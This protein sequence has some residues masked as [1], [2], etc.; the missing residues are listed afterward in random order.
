MKKH[1][2]SFITLFFTCSAMT[3]A[4][5]CAITAANGTATNGLTNLDNATKSITVDKDLNTVVFI[6]RNNTGI[7]GGSSGELRYDISTNGGNSWTNELGILNPLLTSPARY[8]QVAIYNPIGNTNPNNAFLAYMAATYNGTAWTGNVE[9]VRRLNG[10]YNTENYNQPSA[11]LTQNIPKSMVKG[12]PGVFWAIDYDY[13]NANGPGFQV[14]KGNWNN[15]ISDVQ[16]ATNTVITPSFNTSYDGIQ[17]IGDYHIAFD[18]SG[19]KGWISILTHLNGGPSNY[20]LYPVFYSTVNGGTTWNGPFTA[21]ISNSTLF[22]CIAAN[23]DVSGTTVAS[24]SFESDLTVDANGNPHLLTTILNGDNGYVVFFG[25]GFWKEMYDITFNQSLQSFVAYDIAPVNSVRSSGIPGSVTGSVYAWD[26]RPMISR[27]ADGSKIFYN[28][29]DSDPLIVGVGGQNDYPNLYSKA[30][31]I[32]SMTFTNIR[33]FT[34]CNPSIDGQVYFPKIAAEVLQPSSGVY[35]MAGVYTILTNGDMEGP[36]NFNFLDNL[37]WNNADFI[38]PTSTANP[39]VTA[40]ASATSVCDGTPVTLTAVGNASTYIWTA[41]SNS[42]IVNGVPFVPISGGDT[43][44]VHA[45]NVYGCWTEDAITINSAPSLFVIAITSASAICAGT[46][47][48]LSG[49]GAATYTWSGGVTNGVSFIPTATATYTVTG[50]SG[51]GCTNTATTTITVNL[52][53]TVTANSSAASLCVGSSVTLNGGG[54]STYNWTG[55]V[56]NGM[57]F[58]PTF[59]ATYTVT[60]TSNAG[61]T[62]TATTTVSVNALP[63]VT[64]TASAA[65]ICTGTSVTLS[66]GGASTYTWT[67]GVSDGVSF[68]PTAT[69]TYTVTGTS[70]AGCINTAT[71]TII[72]NTS[73]SITA[74][75]SAT[76]LC[77]GTSV[78]LSG[79]GAPSYT[80]T[81]GVTN[82]IGFIPT[83]TATYTVTGTNALG[84]TNTATTTVNVNALPPVTATASAASLCAGTTVILSGGG[85]PTYTWTGGVTN[86]VSF[87]PSSTATYTVTGTNAAGCT[88]TATTTV[89]VNTLPTVTATASAASICAG[90]SVTTNGGGAATYTWTG[91]ITNGVSF[92]PTST[93]TY[94]VTGTNSATLCSNTA[95]VMI[96]VNPLPSV[97]GT[98]TDSVFCLNDAGVTFLALPSG[99]SW[100]GVGVSGI[101]FSPSVAGVGV[102][103]SIYSYTDANGCSN[104]AIVNMTVNALPVVIANASSTS[105]C[106]GNSVILSGGGASL[107]S[108]TGGVNN[109]VSFVPLSTSTYTVTG[110]NL[111]GCINTATTTV[112]VNPAPTVSAQ[113]G[114]QTASVGATV[115]F[116]ITSS[117]SNATYQWQTNLGFGWQ[118]LSSFGQYSGTTNDTLTITNTTMSNNNQ[119]F[120][121]IISSGTCSDSSSVAVL[122]IDNNVGINE[123]ANDNLFSIYPNPTTS[124][125]NLKANTML[126]G[127][128]YRM[129]D[130]TGKTVLSGKI[131]SETSVLELGNLSNGIYLLRIGDN[132]KR[133]FKVIKE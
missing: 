7:F 30:I 35:K 96:T 52:L 83:A 74:T 82:G 65:S 69:T 92:I 110:T 53:P 22:P 133:T 13:A 77:A 121:C 19:Q 130:N 45:T 93:A 31:N 72:V 38:M 95:S 94:T 48:T 43:Y 55:G 59:T 12:A 115:L 54:A 102:H 73:P 16:W 37:T 47:V 118:N 131:N 1:L 84:C 104:S 14:Y 44:T 42:N 103:P 17:R 2:L 105:I 113:S 36:A 108:W 28:W 79:G 21:D 114:N 86:G 81:G 57:S 67:G 26:L 27:T 39:I 129:Y 100:T 122:T 85:A 112:T 116:Y 10:T 127:S 80:W 33:N 66:G 109:A 6:H 97:M 132:V 63:P 101:T 58:I 11:T 124:Q 56:T 75:A 50:A 117:Q 3:N 111:N 126:L 61:C 51:A 62:K 34:A 24:T 15:T 125:I 98:T 4:Q 23:L 99:G 88:K 89:I 119:P 78:T 8:P 25:S 123:L 91:G 9:G 49:F 60:G 18:P 87:I 76:S 41:N 40:T 32:A 5:P 71:K 20:A 68:I 106:D 128:N 29:V 46:P 64:A 90:T 120:R 107:Y 70:A